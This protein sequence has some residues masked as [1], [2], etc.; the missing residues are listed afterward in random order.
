MRAA[1]FAARADSIACT[2]MKFSPIWIGVASALRDCRAAGIVIMADGFFDPGESFG[3]ES[4]T[5]I[6]G[7]VD[8]ERLVIVRHDRDI[9]RHAFSHG[10][11]RG[12]IAFKRWI[13]EAKLYSSKAAIEQLFRF[14][15]AGL[16]RHQ[17]E[18]V[19]VVGG[20]WFGRSAKVRGEW[21]AGRLR[22]RVPA[23]DVETRHCHPDDSLRADETELAQ[24]LRADFH[25]IHRVALY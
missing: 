6:Q 18:T 25:G 17:A 7:F 4:A 8:R 19:A 5:A 16:G 9:A 15:G 21:Q 20:N 2:P 3:I 12:E 14:I 1:E 13:A 22:Q 11:N 10:A 23:S 24:E